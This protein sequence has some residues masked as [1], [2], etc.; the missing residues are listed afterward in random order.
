MRNYV[1]FLTEFVIFM[2]DY[3]RLEHIL[4]HTHTHTHTPKQQHAIKLKQEAF[5]NK[6]D[7]R[8]DIW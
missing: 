4:T 5:H 7:L 6:E 3:R 2:S 1:R 8:E